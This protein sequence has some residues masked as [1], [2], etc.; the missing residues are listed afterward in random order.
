[1]FLKFNFW[2]VVTPKRYLGPKLFFFFRRK[3]KETRNLN[4]WQM[5]VL[6]VLKDLKFSPFGK[7]FKH[8]CVLKVVSII[9]LGMCVL[10]LYT[11][12]SLQK[13]TLSSSSVLSADS[14]ASLTQLFIQKSIQQ[15]ARP[16]SSGILSMAHFHRGTSPEP[17]TP[18]PSVPQGADTSHREGSYGLPAQV[19][20]ESTPAP[21]TWE[22]VK[23]G[24]SSLVGSGT[25]Q[26]IRRLLGHAE[27][28]VTGHLSLASTPGKHHYS[29][30]NASFLSLRQNTQGYHD[31]SC[32]SVEGKIS[33]L[34]A[35]SSS[36][37][38]L[39]ESSLSSSGPLELSAKSGHMSK[40]PSTPSQGREE[41][42]KSRDFCV[43]PRRAEP[44]GCSAADPDRLGPVSLSI[45][46][47]NASSTSDGQQQSQDHTDN[48]GSSSSE[49]SPTHSQTEAEIGVLSD[50]SSEHSLASRVA[51][52][53]QSESSVSVV[54]S[55][56]ST[57]EP[58]ESRARGK[59]FH[60]F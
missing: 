28:L 40:G 50:A 14:G 41:N 24:D 2:G 30:S 18:S 49:I 29:E 46:Q 31:D 56:S 57:A 45:T 4:E 43:A 9:V 35:R 36:D 44:E 32:L 39:K 52:L 3:K 51:K 38:A 60:Y 53:L 54:T 26:E 59:H 21:G 8:F 37:S 23:E 17:L 19:S 15:P 12:D 5:A 22:G 16:A 25:L 13:E 47:R 58:D 11:G 6:F 10:L 33:S 7:L 55:W 1:M 20:L 34:L 27:S 42:T 48:S